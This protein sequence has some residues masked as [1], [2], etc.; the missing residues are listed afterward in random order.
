[1]WWMLVVRGKQR[2]VD[3]GCGRKPNLVYTSK[4]ECS[5]STAM[6]GINWESNFGGH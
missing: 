3:V 5:G 4:V 6:A 1:M 2:V